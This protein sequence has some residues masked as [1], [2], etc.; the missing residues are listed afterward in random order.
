MDEREIHRIYKDD[1]ERML[2]LIDRY[3]CTLLERIKKGGEPSQMKSTIAEYEECES[4][5]TDNCIRYNTLSR[6]F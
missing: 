1:K 3:Q 2:K 6:Q 5:R 4:I